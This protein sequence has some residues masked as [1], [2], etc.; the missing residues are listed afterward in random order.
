MLEMGMCEESV[1]KV[2]L[3][4]KGDQSLGK[5]IPQNMRGIPIGVEWKKVRYP[6][7]TII[8]EV[9]TMKESRR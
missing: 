1:K 8:S 3:G 7:R 9:E 4:Q 5:K 6:M 2:P